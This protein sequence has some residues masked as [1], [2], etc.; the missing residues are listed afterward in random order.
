MLHCILKKKFQNEFCQRK[1]GLSGG[2]CTFSIQT[3]LVSFPLGAG[4]VLNRNFIYALWKER[5]QIDNL[6]VKICK[7]VKIHYINNL[8]RSQ[9]I[10]QF[11][12]SQNPGGGL[13]FLYFC[14]WQPA[15]LLVLFLCKLHHW[16]SLRKSCDSLTVPFSPKVDTCVHKTVCYVIIS[17]V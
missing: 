10:N 15:S 12:T 9:H 7:R 13:K 1:A 3:S 5:L 4:V 11:Y 16:L 14:D 17:A 6:Q 8:H 2:F